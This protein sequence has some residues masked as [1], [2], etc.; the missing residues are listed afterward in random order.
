LAVNARAVKVLTEEGKAAGIEVIT[1]DKKKYAIRSK[2]V[3]LSAGAFEPPLPFA[4][5]FRHSCL[6]HDNAGNQHLD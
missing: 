6:H 3:N 1:P 4:A 2:V 5:S